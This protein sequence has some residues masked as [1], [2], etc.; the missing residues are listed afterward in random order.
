MLI[1]K[2]RATAQG[3]AQPVEQAEALVECAAPDPVTLIGVTVD[4]QMVET[5]D[6]TGNLGYILPGNRGGNAINL[7]DSLQLYCGHRRIQH[8]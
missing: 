6:F 7:A 4:L 2:F 8:Q 5:L 1:D 3:S